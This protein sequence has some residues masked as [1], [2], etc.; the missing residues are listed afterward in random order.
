VQRPATSTS[1][2]PRAE[3]ATKCLQMGR[4][5]HADFFGLQS[6]SLASMPDS[7]GTEHARRSVGDPF[8]FRLVHPTVHRS[9]GFANRSRLWVD[10]LRL[11]T[12]WGYR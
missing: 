2:N 1:G 8:A 5:E 3:R 4:Y 6:R 12:R 10:A 9:R 11:S 7:R